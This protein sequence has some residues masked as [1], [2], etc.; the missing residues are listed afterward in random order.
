MR[1]PKNLEYLVAG[2]VYEIGGIRIPACHTRDELDDLFED[3]GEAG[4]LAALEAIATLFG[5]DGKPVD[6]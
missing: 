6:D 3:L 1:V 4:R 2:A 5:D